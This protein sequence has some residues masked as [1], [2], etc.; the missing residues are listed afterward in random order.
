MKKSSKVLLTL[1]IIIILSLTFYFFSE[2]ISNVTGFAVK[3]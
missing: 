2:W 3:R 1:V